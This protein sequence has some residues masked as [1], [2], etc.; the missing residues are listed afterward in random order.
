[1][2]AT[3]VYKHVC[4]WKKQ[5]RERE[6]GREGG[7]EGQGR[8]RANTRT[9]DS[10]RARARARACP[11]SA[12]VQ[13]ARVPATSAISVASD[14]LDRPRKRLSLAPAATSSSSSSSP[15]RTRTSGGKEPSSSACQSVRRGCSCGPRYSSTKKRQTD[16][17]RKRDREKEHCLGVRAHLPR[18]D[19]TYYTPNGSAYV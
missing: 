14:G 4:V 1:M 9:T 7:R 13:V 18:G 2:G 16:L 8:K 3:N 17:S 5:W 11:F 15:D 6:G 10:T 12:C 19:D